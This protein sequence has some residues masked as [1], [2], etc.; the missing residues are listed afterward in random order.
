MK[1]VGLE[2]DLGLNLSSLL[3]TVWLL[4]GNLIS[5]SLSFFTDK[6]EKVIVHV[7]SFF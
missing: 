2:S 7:A 3:L 5:P 1:S 6:M 4:V